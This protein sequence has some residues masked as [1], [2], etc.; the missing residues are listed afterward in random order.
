MASPAGMT[1]L[2]SCPNCGAQLQPVVLGPDSAP[3]LCALCHISFWVAELSGQARDAWQPTVKCYDWRARRE[4]L[5]RATADEA[6]AASLR[7][8][9]ALPEHL[10]LLSA[11]QLSTLVRVAQGPFASRVKAAA[12]AKAAT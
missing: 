1:Y 4:M 8:T 6:A 5:D 9:S 10:G 12:D 11:G 7:G 3:W 2:L